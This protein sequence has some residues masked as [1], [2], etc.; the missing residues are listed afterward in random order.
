MS[1]KSKRLYFLMFFLIGLGYIVHSQPV[2]K[3]F[4]IL[5]S[6]PNEE[7][8]DKGNFVLGHG[9]KFEIYNNYIF[10]CSQF[11]NKIFQFDLD[12]NLIKQYGKFGQ[13]P[14]DYN[15]P[16]NII[17]YQDE[18]FVFDNGNSRVQVLTG[19][20]KHIKY[21]KIISP[22]IEPII[23]NQRIF[24]FQ[25]GQRNVQ[26]KLIGVY[27]VKGTKLYEFGDPAG[28]KS[29]YKENIY[30]RALTVKLFNQRIHTLQKYD[31]MY[32][33]YTLDG[34]LERQFKLDINPLDDKEYKK[35]NRMYAYSRFTINKDLIYAP[36]AAKGK[37]VI[38]IFDMKGKYQYTYQKT[39]S[40]D[41]L[42][43][44]VELEF[45]SIVGVEYLYLLLLDPEMNF[46][47]I[48]L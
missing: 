35:L 8:M 39:M 32:R 5:K 21:L 13:G 2:I 41:D 19:E 48:K 22:F 23:A 14:G 20:L 10:F 17:P 34:K 37:L 24:L 26:K 1:I 25:L 27:D 11:Q 7:Q 18:I 4:K 44:P 12:G 42:Y 30:H 31:T 28:L 45:T 15:K 43:Y 3:Q 16:S 36:L 29:R 6:F 47:K 40:G 33:I 9:T 46:L 38:N